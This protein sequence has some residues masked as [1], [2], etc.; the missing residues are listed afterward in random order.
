MC[1]LP[2]QTLPQQPVG[3]AISLEILGNLEG[4]RATIRLWMAICLPHLTTH[5]G[6]YPGHQGAGRAD[7]PAL[8]FTRPQEVT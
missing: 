6:N 8:P 3:T 2:P 7:L 4:L 1:I 5:E